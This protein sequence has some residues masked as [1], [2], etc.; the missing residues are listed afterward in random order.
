MALAQLDTADIQNRDPDPPRT[1][2]PLDDY[3]DIDEMDIDSFAGDIKNFN[4]G[5]LLGQHLEE[6]E[7]GIDDGGVE[8]SGPSH[9]LFA[10]SQSVGP[11]TT[12]VASTNVRSSTP[13]SSEYEDLTFDEDEAVSESLSPFEALPTE[14]SFA[15][16]PA[17]LTNTQSADSVYCVSNE[18]RPGLGQACFDKPSLR[19]QAQP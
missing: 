15:S 19:H 2:G 9:C 13:V 10:S 14:V 12:A 11:N 1:A 16:F 6:K 8:T 3:S 4:E 5:T 17:S 18:L 7:D